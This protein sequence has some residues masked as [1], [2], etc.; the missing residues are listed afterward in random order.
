MKLITRP[1]TP[2]QNAAN[3]LAAWK[4][5]PT[6]TPPVPGLTCCIDYF[7]PVC[8]QAYSYIPGVSG[9]PSC[10][11][12]CKVFGVVALIRWL[13]SYTSLISAATPR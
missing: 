8:H 3:A 6:V 13:P 12:G 10:P 11:F 4:E 2:E 7:C 5:L 1:V 9:S